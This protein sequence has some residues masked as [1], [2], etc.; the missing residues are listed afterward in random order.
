ML[1]L[2]I[3][4][5]L[6]I[7]AISCQSGQVSPQG[8]PCDLSA[9]GGRSCNASMVFASGDAQTLTPSII[10]YRTDLL[11]A[12]TMSP[13]DGRI[14]N[15]MKLE[16]SA[17]AYAFLEIGYFDLPG[18]ALN[19][20][21]SGAGLWYY[22]V[23]QDASGQTIKCLQ[24]V[25]Q[26]D[27]GQ[28]VRLEIASVGPDPR[29]PTSFKISMV[30]PNTNLDPCTVADCTN[31]LWTAG[32][33][34]F[35]TVELRQSLHGKSGA[36]AS[37]AFFKNNSYERPNGIFAFQTAEG[38]VSADNPPF[39]GIFQSPVSGSSGGTFFVQ[40]C[41]ATNTVYP[42]ELNFGKVSVGQS[43]SQTILISNIKPASGAMNIA[44][45][46]VTGAN[47]A[48][49]TIANS[50]GNSL[51]PL[52]SCKVTITFK[53]SQQSQRNATLTVT[54]SGGSGSGTDTSTLLGTG[55]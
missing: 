12:A 25:P 42:I 39:F 7:F 33:S 1:K 21:A 15:S 30:T 11:V 45:V 35:A 17:N 32:S 29:Q 10:G 4:L 38:R 48:D 28:Y 55:G 2:S 50:C 9:P 52:A 37:T 16:G 54:D 24:P 46:T 13:G 18:V 3:C 49:F 44:G 51:A 47:A 5:S 31:V 14:G 53:P 43:S 36:S 27:I 19:C 34:K 41:V 6:L 8:Y 20:G 22:I 26:A 23:R 40:C